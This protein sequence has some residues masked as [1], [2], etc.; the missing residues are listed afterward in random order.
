M[1]IWN[2]KEEVRG[3][4]DRKSVGGRGFGVLTGLTSLSLI[5]PWW[6]RTVSRGGDSPSLEWRSAGFRVQGI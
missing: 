1:A 6:Q 4:R 5:S 2:E 3:D